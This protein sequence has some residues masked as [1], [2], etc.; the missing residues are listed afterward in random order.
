MNTLTESPQAVSIGGE[1]IQLEH[2][3]GH[4][5]MPN[6]KK[7]LQHVLRILKTSSEASDWAILPGLLKGLHSMGKDP[8]PRVRARI[9][10]LAAL[11]GQFGVILVAL[12]KVR[13]TGFTLKDPLTLGAVVWGLRQVAERDNWNEEGVARAIKDANAVATLLESELHG[14]GKKLRVND[15]R[16]R[17]SVLGVYLELAAVYAWRFKDGQD[18]DGKVEAFAERLMSNVSDEQMTVR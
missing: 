17:P 13:E 3:G 10:R 18:V 9:V 12:G 11:R 16:T 4:G 8:P 6:R 1:E 14:S 5:V 7:Q 15:P 2:L